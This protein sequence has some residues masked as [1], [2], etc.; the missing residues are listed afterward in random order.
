MTG[1]KSKPLLSQQLPRIRIQHRWYGD[2]HYTFVCRGRGS[3]GWGTSAGHAY[4]QWAHNY[5]KRLVRW[6]SQYRDH[7]TGR[8]ADMKTQLDITRSFLRRVK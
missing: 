8:Y 5:Q 6:A 3:I 4:K 1:I 7:G 2:V